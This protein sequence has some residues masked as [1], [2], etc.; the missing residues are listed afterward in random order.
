MT[1]PPPPPPPFFMRPPPLSLLRPG[2][3][4]TGHQRLPPASGGAEWRVSMVVHSFDEARGTLTGTMAAS[5]LPCGGD[6]GGILTYLTGE[7]VDNVNHGLFTDRWGASHAIDFTH[8]RRLGAPLGGSFAAL[9]RSGG[10]AAGL[11][12]CGSVFLRL[13]EHFFLPPTPPDW[14]LTI[15][16]FYYAA[17]DRA[18]GRLRG[19]YFERSLDVGPAFQQLELRPLDAPGGRSAPTFEMR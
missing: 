10:R 9:E 14:A 13:K 18:S 5:G 3:L 2:L 7:V 15:G 8:W 19:L 16:G 17:L 4:L 6:V 11:A 12:A 1:A